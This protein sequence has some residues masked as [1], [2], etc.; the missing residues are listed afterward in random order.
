[1]TATSTTWHNW[2]SK[3]RLAVVDA[4]RAWIERYGVP[5]SLY[6]DWKN[7]YKRAP[8]VKE[9]L[10]EKSRSRSLGACARSWGSKLI[11]ASSPQAKGRVEAA[12]R[13]ASGPAG[14]ETA[15]QQISSHEVANVYL[16]NEYLPEHNRRFARTAAKAEDYHPSRAA[17]GGT[18]PDFPIGERTHNQ[19]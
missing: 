14:E 6:V 15:R 4:R 2:A 9:Q 12:T 8:T 19:Q 16:K 10:R 13:H 18:G 1:M 17:E 11:A 7:L 3:R 5:H